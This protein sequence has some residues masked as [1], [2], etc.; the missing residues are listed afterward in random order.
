MQWILASEGSRQRFP[1]VQ[2]LPLIRI[3]IK[4]KFN[5]NSPGHQ[6]IVL[7]GREKKEFVIR[8][9]MLV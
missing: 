1:V 8:K 9:N 5:I 4:Q 3:K 7:N 6:V 2:L